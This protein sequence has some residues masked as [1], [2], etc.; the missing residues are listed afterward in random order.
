MRKIQLNYYIVKTVYCI[1]S[2]NQL[3][4]SKESTLTRSRKKFHKYES[5][6]PVVKAMV[7]DDGSEGA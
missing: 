6:D 7:G 4:L 3:G 1:D 2:P 5:N